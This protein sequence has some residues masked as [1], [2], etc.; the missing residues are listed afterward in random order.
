MPPYAAMVE[1]IGNRGIAPATI[2]PV[3]SAQ[4]QVVG[5]QEWFASR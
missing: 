4:R 1:G 5:W 3:S 2:P